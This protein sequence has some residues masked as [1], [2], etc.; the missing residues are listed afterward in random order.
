VFDFQNDT[1]V[2]GIKD[3]FMFGPALLVSPV[4]AAGATSRSVYLP[5]GTWY[6]FWSGRSYAG[7]QRV[8]VRP[9]LEQVPLFV[10][11]G[12]L[13]PLARATLHT[14]DPLSGEL[15]ARAFGAAN[16]ACTLYE[17]DGRHSPELTEVV[18]SWEPARRV[19]SLRRAGPTRQP[20]YRVAEWTRVI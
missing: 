16:A 15:T 14:D 20:N 7:A 8:E 5:A 3:Q 17:D 12:T 11:S 13:L 6:D 18:L 4:T 2:Y 1:M 9:S 10:R 19:G